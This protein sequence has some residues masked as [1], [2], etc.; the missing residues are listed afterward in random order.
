LLYGFALP[1]NSGYNN[2]TVLSD[3]KNANF[4]QVYS[5]GFRRVDISSGVPFELSFAG[6]DQASSLSES[7][8]Q[9]LANKASGTT[10]VGFLFHH[11]SDHTRGLYVN[12]TTF[13][14][15][16]A[17]LNRNKFVVVLQSQ[18][19]AIYLDY[20][21]KR[22]GLSLAFLSEILSLSFFIILF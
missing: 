13:E 19:P 8:F 6:I 12:V 14:D 5:S 7:Y 20:V 4:S 10:L 22:A 21:A 16:I 18:L 9:S 1:Y 17:Y 3:L 11:V 15:D 2:Q